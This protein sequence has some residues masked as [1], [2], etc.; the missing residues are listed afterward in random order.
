M[1]F[2]D[3]AWSTSFQITRKKHEEVKILFQDGI[4][5]PSLKTDS[6][7]Y[8]LYL[9][10]P[11]MI[12]EEKIRYQDIISSLNDEFVK[13]LVWRNFKASVFHLSMH[14]AVSNF[15]VYA[16]WAKNKNPEL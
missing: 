1:D 16:R 6:H 7:G 3:Y 13:K 12:G 9:A 14:A 5:F 4:L 15:E 10:K 2:F 8:V 11:K